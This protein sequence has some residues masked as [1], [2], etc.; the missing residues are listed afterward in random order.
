MVTLVNRAKVGTATTG[1]G[2]VTLGSAEDG[3]QTL[4]DAGVV[5]ANVVRY[6]IEDGSDWEIGTG[7]YTASGTTLSRTVTESSN[8][9][10]ALNL[11]GNAAVFVGATAEDLG[12]T[13]V[14]K[15]TTYTA[16]ANDAVIA[17]TSGGVWTL[18]LPASPASGAYIRI[19]DGADWATNN[20]TVSRNGQT[21]DGTAA[22][23]VVNIGN[24]SI[25][26]VF[27]GTTWQVTAQFGGQGGDAVTLTGTQTLTNKTVALG[28]NTISG[29]TA[30]FNTALTDGDFSTLAG[31][32]TLTNK[33]VALGSNTVSGTT[34]EFNTALTDASFSTLAGTETLTNKTLT[35]P[36]FDGTPLAPT[37]TVGT[38]TT[39]VAT[40]AFVLANGASSSVAA[41]TPAATVDIS[42]ADDDY[43]TITLDQNT[44]FTM[45]DVD[46]GVDTFN[47]AIT[48]YDIPT[49]Y[50]LAGVS[51][52][53]V[54]FSV[55]SQENAPTVMALSSDGTKMYVAGSTGNTV[56]QYTLS[57][58][59]DMSTASYASLSFSVSSQVSGPYGLEFS[60]D[61]TK[62]YVS[63]NTTKSLYQYTLSTAWNVSTASYDSVSF[64]FGSQ[65]VGGNYPRGFSFSVD[66]TKLVV[67]SFA[68]IAY[69]YTLSTAWD[70]ST[71]SYDSISLSVTAQDGQTASIEWSSDGTLL[72][73]FGDSNNILYQY[74]LST[75][76]NI[77]TASYD[78]VSFAIAGD[79]RD[80]TF[81]A[82]GI[83][84]FA[85]KDSGDAVAQF[86]TQLLTQVT[87]TYPASFNFTSGSTPLGPRAGATDIFDAQTTDGGVS[88]YVT[89]VNAA[90][91]LIPI[92]TKQTLS[93]VAATDIALTGNYEAYV[94]K[95]FTFLPVSDNQILE[96]RTSSDGG[97][98][99]DSGSSD[100]G[101]IGTA[102][103]TP[104]TPLSNFGS[105][106]ANYNRLLVAALTNTQGVR[107]W[108]DGAIYGK[109]ANGEITIYQPHETDQT[110]VSGSSHFFS[111]G[112]NVTVHN[113]SGFR[114]SFADVDTVRLTFASGNISS[115][116][117]QLYGVVTG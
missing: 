42:L 108:A 104:G 47:L 58:A 4:A 72:F 111:G 39:Q 11:S 10:S 36:T 71:I 56:Y 46:A 6:V 62:M 43:F 61:G 101:Y 68:G 32:Q 7:V 78:S 8:A 48:G 100:Y 28:S 106:G 89:K 102:Q 80:F 65:I 63:S 55:G 18:T 74:T 88:W 94:I 85:L 21:I 60:S 67:G 113:Y 52:D 25:D 57:T 116:Q 103:Q 41:L 76:F 5:D 110:I 77:S 109:G 22:D 59:N 44:T 112:S 15:T 98:S 117:Y 81:S 3:Y 40:T 50:N 69:Q 30:E 92:G 93:N 96:L 2:T 97:S 107:Q 13:W 29:T 45:S 49:G 53:S 75:A 24:I 33:T 35:S 1:T 37:A 34:A 70:L 31:T 73:V 105:N 66:G 79:V 95:F 82:D 87:T 12:T 38:D 86:T 54:S 17:D 84:L 91:G 16:A 90:S 23:L 20:L 9:G 99:F 51:D 114:Y 27:D 14:R 26:L 83:K 64:S 19:L 115:G